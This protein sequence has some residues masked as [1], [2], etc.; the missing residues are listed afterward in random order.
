MKTRTKLICFL[1]AVVLVVALVI[2]GFGW[3]SRQLEGD[4]SSYIAAAIQRDAVQ[5]YA[6]EGSYPTSLA[7]LEQNYG[8]SI[9]ATRYNVYYQFMG[10]NLL[11]QIHV[12]AIDQEPEA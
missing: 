9:D 5:C 10:A 1:V 11:P 8:L 6:V 2:G 12:F 4:R 3:F 7:Y